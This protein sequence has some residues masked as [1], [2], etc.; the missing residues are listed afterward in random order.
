MSVTYNKIANLEAAP[1]KIK[2][3]DSNTD[4]SNHTTEEK[5]SKNIP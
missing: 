3:K 4:I 5:I 1:G 2:V